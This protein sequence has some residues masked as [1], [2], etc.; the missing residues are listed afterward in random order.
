MCG[1][2]ER[3]DYGGKDFKEWL[4]GWLLLY[5]LGTF[6]VDRHDGNRL[7]VRSALFIVCCPLFPSA[8]GF[9]A[10]SMAGGRGQASDSQ[11]DADQGAC[12][13]TQANGQNMRCLSIG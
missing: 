1:C 2:S 5:H 12:T 9:V 8:T 13:D 4:E 7:A 3:V 6:F 11:G 10:G